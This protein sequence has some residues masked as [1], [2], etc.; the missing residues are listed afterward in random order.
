M[1]QA[2][3][4]IVHGFVQGVSF[5]YYTRQTAK[6]LSLGGHVRNLPN[7]TVEVWAEGEENKLK[8]LAAW[9]EHGPSYAQVSRVDLSWRDPIGEDSHFTIKF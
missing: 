6:D 2:F 4:A 3:Y 8:E 7:G 9:L 1:T 5:R